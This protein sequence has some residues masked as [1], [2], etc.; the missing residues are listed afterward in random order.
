M[1]TALPF[2]IVLI[3]MPASGKS[4]IA[5]AL[6]K[7]RGYTCVDTDQIIEQTHQQ[8]LQELIAAH[9]IEQFH[10]IEADA[11]CG[12]NLSD[13]HDGLVVSTGGSVVY[14][15]RAMAHLKQMGTVVHLEV[16]MD[17]LLERIG[18]LEERGVTIAPG[19]TFEDLYHERTRL[20]H[21]YRDLGIKSSG[22]SVDDTVELIIATLRMP[23]RDGV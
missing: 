17:Q 9:G 16:E 22:L 13:Y 21:K 7:R 10:E 5:R 4:T 1:C 8:T 19:Q 18:S 3:G 14:Q 15:P 2:C 23:R 20:Y 6:A 12:L 11:C